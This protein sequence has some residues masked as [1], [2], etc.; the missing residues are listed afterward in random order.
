MIVIDKDYPL[1]VEILVD[2]PCLAMLS[3]GQVCAAS[4]NPYCREDFLV[5]D[6]VN[7]GNRCYKIQ[8]WERQR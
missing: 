2:R 5:R 7:P 1:L 6:D 4:I 3:K 8:I